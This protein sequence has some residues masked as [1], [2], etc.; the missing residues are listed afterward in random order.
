[1]AG[2]HL[3]CMRTRPP[4]PEMSDWVVITD[5]TPNHHPARPAPEAV[6]LRR[7]VLTREPDASGD[8]ASLHQFSPPTPPMMRKR[9]ASMKERCSGCNKNFGVFKHRVRLSLCTDAQTNAY[10]TVYVPCSERR[11]LRPIADSILDRL[12]TYCRHCG[13]GTYVCS[14]LASFLAPGSLLPHTKHARIFRRTNPS[15]PGYCSSCCKFKVPRSLVRKQPLLRHDICPIPD[16][17]LPPPPALP[18][19]CAER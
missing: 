19:Y 8:D 14:H 3:V 7:S 6:D 13:D 10:K 5:R 9:S 18:M 1:M 11:T 4:T 16:P 15:L 17:P 2:S 12:Q